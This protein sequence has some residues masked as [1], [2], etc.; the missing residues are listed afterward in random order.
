MPKIS[1]CKCSHFVFDGF[2][3]QQG[4][5]YG[6]TYGKKFVTNGN[7]NSQ[8][9]YNIYW[10]SVNEYVET[11]WTKS[12]LS[13]ME[14]PTL[15]SA[16]YEAA[17]KRNAIG[18]TLNYQTSAELEQVRWTRDEQH[19]HFQDHDPLA[20]PRLPACPNQTAS[21]KYNSSKERNT[22]TQHPNTIKYVYGNKVVV[23]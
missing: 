20:T 15:F 3:V 7:L 22:L 6:S 1:R 4:M 13:F 10:Q 5:L 11:I 19:R 17:N 14:N 2:C 9:Y 21:V 23:I 12:R 8:G 16:I 18:L